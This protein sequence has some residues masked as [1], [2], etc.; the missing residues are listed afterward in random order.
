MSNPEEHSRS[1]FEAGSG[2]GREGGGA[3]RGRPGE[4]QRFWD[5]YARRTRHGGQR[6][7]RESAGEAGNGQGLGHAHECV[8]WCPICRTAD[9]LRASAPPELRDQ[10]QSVQRD[11]LVTIRALLDAYLERIEDGPR[12]R[13]QSSVEDIPIE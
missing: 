8:E 13:R 12:R 3:G 6:A 5:E 7:E 9:L 11:A 4:A 1:G 2:G 10:V